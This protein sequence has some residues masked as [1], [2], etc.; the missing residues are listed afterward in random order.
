MGGGARV[1]VVV[2]ATFGMARDSDARLIAPL[3]V[4]TED[5]SHA[6][7][8]L[9]EAGELAPYL[10][11]AGVLLAGHACSPRPVQALTARLA[12]FRERPLVDKSL[13]VF[14]DRDSAA[15]SARPFTKMPF[16]Y[17]R[18]YGGAGF[19]DNPV[20]VGAAGSARA[21]PNLLDP[22]NPHKPAGFGPLARRWGA[23]LRLLGARVPEGIDG[24]N[25]R[26][27]EGFDWRY[28][29]AAP[30]D[31]QCELLHGD[32]WIVLDGMSPTLPRLQTRLPRCA[33]RRS[34]SPRAPRA[35]PR[36]RR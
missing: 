23:R 14:G 8:S 30:A 15:A 28:F 25:A 16:E 9:V 27:P 2:K 29:H 4:V 13:H 11:S 21:L 22:V 36:G 20:G 35:S 1:T 26:I 32:E 7:G 5:R 6:G 10:P 17:E 34:G 18:A 24:P 19:L 31:Q 3:P 33:P 12:V